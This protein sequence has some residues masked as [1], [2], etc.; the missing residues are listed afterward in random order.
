MTVAAGAGC[1]L[2]VAGNQGCGVR[3]L[4]VWLAG[5]E[6]RLQAA[7][8][9]FKVRGWA[10]CGWRLRA[11]GALCGLRVAGCRWGLRAGAQ[12]TGCGL[13]VRVRGNARQAARRLAGAGCALRLAG[14]ECGLPPQPTLGARGEWRLR[15]A[16]SSAGWRRGRRWAPGAGGD[17]ELQVRFAGCDRVASLRWGLRA[18]SA[19]GGWR[20]A[21]CNEAGCVLR[22]PGCE[23]GLPT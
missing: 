10:P 23:C 14:C 4:R 9:G 5:C 3:V 21:R 19:G 1:E 11:A 2:R 12:V 7:G 8:A 6:F 13:R 20:V 17:C 18:A 16:G 22:V 15:V